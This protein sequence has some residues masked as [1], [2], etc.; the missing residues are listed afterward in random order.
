MLNRVKTKLGLLET[1]LIYK[2]KKSTNNPQ[3]LTVDVCQEVFFLGNIHLL[4]KNFFVIIKI[5]LFKKII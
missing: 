2:S 5:I 4:F 3:F 1:L